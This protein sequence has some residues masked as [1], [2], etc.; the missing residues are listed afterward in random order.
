MRSIILGDSH[1]GARG[2]DDYYYTEQKRFFTEDLFPYMK[3]EG[4]NTIWQLGDL[5]EVRKTTNNEMVQS[6][7]NDIFD[8]ML[9]EDIHFYTLAG[10]HDLY[11][12]HSSRIYNPLNVLGGYSNIHFIREFETIEFDGLPV[13]FIGWMNKGNKERIK[14]AIY[15]SGSSY[16]LGHF[17]ILGHPMH[18]GIENNHA[19]FESHFL[20][21]YTKVYSGH[22]HTQ[23]EKG[24]IKYVGTPYETSWADYNDPK[25]FHVFDTATQTTEFIQN[26]NI[27]Y[28]KIEYP[29]KNL[30]TFKYAAYAGSVVRCVVLE[31]DDKLDYF[32]ENLAKVKTKELSVVDNTDF[33]IS[34]AEIDIEIE[35]TL[36]VLIT[37]IKNSEINNKTHVI[38]LIKE[39]H[40]ESL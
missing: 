24:N 26:M 6:I 23:S 37:T 5:F 3:K 30:S 36:S 32:L 12:R 4:I 20:N 38:K 18:K 15:S 29:I 28:K 10:N 33:I 13:D 16:A 27:L 40:A 22:F 25:G 17:E 34:D 21:G 9:Q 1:F 14:N 31:R 2:F 39:I 11:L 35:S 8:H 19:G 7:R